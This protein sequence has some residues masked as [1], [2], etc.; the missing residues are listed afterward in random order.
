MELPCLYT[1]RPSPRTCPFGEP[2]CPRF[3]IVMRRKSLEGAEGLCEGDHLVSSLLRT[4]TTSQEE[5]ESPT[6]GPLGL[7]NVLGSP[8][9]NVRDSAS[10]KG[11]RL[12]KTVP[13]ISPHAWI[14][15]DHRRHQSTRES[16]P[17]DA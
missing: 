12:A 6:D 3:T 2:Y 9:S 10:H 8:H 13:G 5:S 16:T 17:K 1:P 4:Q 7:M 11:P 14:V 15:T